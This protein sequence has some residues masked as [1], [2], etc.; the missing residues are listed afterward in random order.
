MSRRGWDRSKICYSVS[1][2]L[3]SC[4]VQGV[5]TV[6]L[7]NKKSRVPDDVKEHHKSGTY[8]SSRSL[9]LQGGGCI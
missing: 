8:T 3:D 4:T 1:R 7:L 9:I 2:Q 6:W 5:V